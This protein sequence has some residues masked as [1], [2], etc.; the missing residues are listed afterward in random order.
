[1]NIID[2]LKEDGISP[3]KMASTHGAEYAS[4][5]PWCGGKDRFRAWPN[6]ENGGNY[7]CRKCQKS[8]GMIRYLTDY[9]KMPYQDACVLIGRIP[10]PQKGETEIQKGWHPAPLRNPPSAKWQIE[11]ERLIKWGEGCLWNPTYINIVK[12][13]NERGLNDMAIKKA[14]LGWLTQ[15]FFPLR[16]TWGLPPIARED[17]LTVKLR[18]PAGLI[19]PYFQNGRAQRIRVRLLYPE[20]DRRYYILPGS[21]TNP[22]VLNGPAEGAIIVE[23]DL[24]AILIHQE[25][26]D[27]LTVLSL[28]SAVMK[29]DA[30][31]YEI[32]KQAE[33]VLVSLDRDEAGAL[34]SRWWLGNFPNAKRWPVPKDFG[35]DPSEA[36]QK[37]LHIRDWVLAGITYSNP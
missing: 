23:S 33:I 4:K 10:G 31:T 20:N 22:M 7:W 28:G 6:Q 29:P 30:A 2:L 5:C 37:G 27:S 19:I 17:R 1:M 8:G 26:G 32:L 14:R 16:E 9:R 35:K 15:D 25:A 36:F 11:G 3:A 12:Q 21:N 34:N 13:I 18:I 24:D